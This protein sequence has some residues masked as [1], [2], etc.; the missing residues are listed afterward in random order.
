[1][2]RL[3]CPRPSTFPPPQARSAEQVADVERAG[4]I[5]RG[6]ETIVETLVL[7]HHL[8]DLHII[9]TVRVRA[10]FTREHGGRGYPIGRWF[11]SHASAIN[12]D[13]IRLALRT[14]R[15]VA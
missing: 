2:P 4:I 13:P 10:P 12:H 8:V 7:P 5:A 9:R 3:P 6:I 15:K 1:M 11:D 14:S